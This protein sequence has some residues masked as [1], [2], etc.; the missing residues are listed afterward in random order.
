MWRRAKI[1]S[2]RE[3]LSRL[4]TRRD[5]RLPTR[6]TLGVSQKEFEE[7]LQ[8]FSTEILIVQPRVSG[9]REQGLLARYS[10]VLA[11]Y[12]DSL[13]L[14]REA[15]AQATRSG[16]SA[17]RAGPPPSIR[18]ENDVVAIV[19]RH[20]LPTAQAADGSGFIPRESVS[21]LWTKARARFAEANRTAGVM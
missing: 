17:D 21:F 4:A 16:F 9:P 8:A 19:Q 15:V 10:E 13:R 18:V 5:T 14:W 11:T 2:R 1:A 3:R 6:D 20:G 12:E 7:L